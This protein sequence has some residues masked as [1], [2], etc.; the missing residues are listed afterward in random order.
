MPILDMRK[1]CGL[2]WS[3]IA[4]N[5]QLKI[6]SIERLRSLAREKAKIYQDGDLTS[7]ILPVYQTHKMSQLSL[8]F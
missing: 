7:N 5:K 6:G 8:H 2:T 3:M 1:L 4:N